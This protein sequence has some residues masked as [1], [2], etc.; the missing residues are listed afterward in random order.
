MA[1]GSVRVG[2]HMKHRDGQKSEGRSRRTEKDR[3]ALKSFREYN[4]SLILDPVVL[5]LGTEGPTQL[6]QRKER[7]FG[8]K[9]DGQYFQTHNVTGGLCRNL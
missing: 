8:K 9:G 7:H 1:H 4:D 3:Q 5:R 2:A 6:P